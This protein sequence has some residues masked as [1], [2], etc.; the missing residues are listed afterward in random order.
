MSQVFISY[1]HDDLDFVRALEAQLE[2]SN[3]EVWTD[4]ELRGGQNWRAA[5]DDAIKASFA[6]IA[7]ITPTASQSAYVTYEWS[8]AMGLGIQVI[9]IKLVEAEFHPKL[10]VLQYVDFS[11]RFK[12]PWEKLID[13][14]LSIKK[15]YGQATKTGPDIGGKQVTISSEIQQAAVYL[16]ST[17]ANQRKTAVKQLA[18]IGEL[19]ALQALENALKHQY[20]DVRI[21]AALNLSRLTN[22]RDEQVLPS[23]FEGLRGELRVDEDWKELDQIIMSLET[24]GKPSL[25]GLIDALEIRNSGVREKVVNALGSIGDVSAVAHIIEC[26]LDDDSLVR[27]TAAEA[28]GRIGDNTAVPA[29]S[30]TLWDEDPRVRCAAAVALGKIGDERAV[31][32]L[33]QV[34]AAEPYKEG[35]AVI[36]RALARIGNNEAMEVVRHW[37]TSAKG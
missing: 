34:L 21:S 36:I 4:T 32:S 1:S 12:E 13:L 9:P 15:E 17:D 29:L 31:N 10:T 3:I 18:Q 5:I 35:E 6:V 14:L 2:K 19:E 30:N 26:L 7:V 28:L 25:P 23:L 24:I 16:N 22:Y 20:R 8:F 33:I 27:S 37:K 11:V